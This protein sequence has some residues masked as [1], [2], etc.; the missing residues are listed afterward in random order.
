MGRRGTISSTEFPMQKGEGQGR[1]ENGSFLGG[2][3][4]KGGREPDLPENHNNGK[5]GRSTLFIV[6][7]RYRQSR[8]R[9][10][11]SVPNSPFQRE[12]L[13]GRRRSD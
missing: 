9:P 4:E 12:K 10:L 8:Y 11:F 7:E 13:R 6:P 5:R 1:A 2:G 3:E